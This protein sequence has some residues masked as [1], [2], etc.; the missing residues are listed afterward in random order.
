LECPRRASH[1]HLAFG[2]VNVAMNEIEYDLRG[3]IC[4]ATLLLCLRELNRFK[5]KLQAGAVRLA[6][7]IDNRDATS[8]LPDAAK[9]M[10]YQVAV[11][12][13]DGYYLLQIGKDLG[14]N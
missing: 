2:P 11:D 7:K 14:G 9:N 12:K 4:P 5:E 6:V 3:Q 8:T 13:C 1:L 10:G